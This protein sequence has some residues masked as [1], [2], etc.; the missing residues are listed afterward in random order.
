[1][2]RR[3]KTAARET[4]ESILDA[5]IKVFY[6]R[7]VA[8][9]SLTEIAELAGVTRGAVYVHFRDKADLVWALSQ[10][11]RFP[12]DA[13]CD[14]CPDAITQDPLGELQKQWLTLF[15]E[16][17]HNKEWQLIF[18][19]VFHRI[20]LVTESGAIRDRVMEGYTRALSKMKH[21]LSLAVDHGQL[22]AQ[23]DI[24]M[25]AMLLNGSLMGVLED[26]LMKPEAYDLPAVGERA[27]QAI[28]GMLHLPPLSKSGNN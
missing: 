11:I 3:T 28:F 20:E 13:L 1:M 16:L 17:A 18:A 14:V 8:R 21:F 4:R 2:A 9:A 15:Q 23:L 26:W 25:A 27:V 12:A 24:D 5:A 7:G 22:P 6:E 19:I 10:R